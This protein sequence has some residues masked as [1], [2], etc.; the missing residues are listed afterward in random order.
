MKKTLIFVMGLC[1]ACIVGCTPTHYIKTIQE[2]TGA[3]GKKKRTDIE[4]VS[5]TDTASKKLKLK[6]IEWE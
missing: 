4:S 1:I 6:N 3:D 5:Q 2:E